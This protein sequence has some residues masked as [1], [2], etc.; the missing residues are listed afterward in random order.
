MNLRQQITDFYWSHVAELPQT[1]Q[2]HLATRLAAWNNDSAALSLLASL[3]PLYVPEPYD[4]QT[5]HDS[6]SELIHNPPVERKN[7]SKLREKYFAKYPELDGLHLAL[8]RVRHLLWVYGTDVRDIF[9]ELA[10]KR[11]CLSLEQ[12][13]HADDDAMRTLSTYAINY[14]YLLE[15]V[16]LEREQ[17]RAIDV[18]RLYNLGDGYDMDNR[19]HLQ[20]LIYLYTHCII[21]ETNFYA[22]AIPKA[23]LP[24]YQAMLRRL[25]LV[26][27]KHYDDINLDNK[28]EF[29]VCCR[30]C[31]F[32]SP[33][34]SRI[35][36]ECS[37]SVSDAG[38]FLIDR[39][40]NNAQSSRVTFI[41]SEHRNVLF[42]MSGSP[43]PHV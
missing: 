7:A 25:E 28:L 8:F 37:K 31:S 2:F 15:R 3:K 9:F 41:D 13:L 14:T 20:L 6:L 17:S 33:L 11:H 19:S 22:H 30:I 42:L 38:T 5:V 18:K 26:I 27:T 39:H 16:I 32:D 4:S 40:N 10:S 23:L 1:K 12:K 43:Y 35:E 29:L 34:F 21:G 24:D 36:D